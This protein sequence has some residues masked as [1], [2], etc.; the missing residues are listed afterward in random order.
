MVEI[1]DEE[2]E[3]ALDF[4]RDEAD[5]MGLAMGNQAK[6]HAMLRHVKAL[7]MKASGEKAVSAQEREAYASPEYRQAI[8]DEFEAV[9]EAARMRALREAASSKL[10]CWRSAGANQRAARI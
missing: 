3:K 1:S 9:R 5:N 10:D 4:L 8:E 2:V 7:A 6:A